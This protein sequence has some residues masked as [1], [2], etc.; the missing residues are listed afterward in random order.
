M[1]SKCASAREH[2]FRN[3]RGSCI[4]QGDAGWNAKDCRQGG[5]CLLF[6]ERDVQAELSQGVCLL[7]RR[8]TV[9]G[10]N[11]WSGP[12]AE[13]PAIKIVTAREKAPTNP[14]K[15]FRPGYYIPCSE[16]QERIAQ[17][18]P[19]KSPFAAGRLL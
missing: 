19:K 8:C 11:D 5:T 9:F 7:V 16:S 2:I 1:H 14:V 10:K 13:R 18:C 3:G 6:R 15:Y 17:V 4:R 12:T